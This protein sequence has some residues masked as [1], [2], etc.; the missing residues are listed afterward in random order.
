VRFRKFSSVLITRRREATILPILARA[1]GTYG[2]LEGGEDLNRR[3]FASKTAN[4]NGILVPL[5]GDGPGGKKVVPC[6]LRQCRDITTEPQCCWIPLTWPVREWG[7]ERERDGERERAFRRQ[8]YICISRRLDAGGGSARY[9]NLNS[10]HR[11]TRKIT[12][13][14]RNKASNC[15]HAPSVSPS[16]PSYGHSIALLHF[17]RS[18]A[19]RC[20]RFVPC[21]ILTSLDRAGY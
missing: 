13:L 6:V 1:K 9:A 12:V 19:G 17:P 3:L 18:R 14:F 20:G 5:G 16:P 21:W 10:P 2:W 7:R 4:L 8:D 11:K 15:L